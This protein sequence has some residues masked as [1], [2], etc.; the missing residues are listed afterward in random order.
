MRWESVSI[1]LGHEIYEL[2][3]KKDKLLTLTFHPGTN[4]ARIETAAERRVLLI[5]KE[6]FRKHKTV[7]R[8]EYGILLGQFISDDKDPIIEMG[9]EKFLCSV[10]DKSGP[11]LIIYKEI[12]KKQPLTFCVLNIPDAN[13]F[14]SKQKK[15]PVILHSSLLLA[16]CWY[17]LL[18][19]AKEKIS[20]YSA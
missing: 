5:R 8:T 10:Q 7:L 1:G 17:L 13:H 6:G 9:N 16:L 2:W 11:E 19:T 20:E 4:S 3:N 14:F 15:F 12:K 18:P